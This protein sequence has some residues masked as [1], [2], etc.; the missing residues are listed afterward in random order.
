MAASGP[1]GLV[2]GRLYQKCG[3]WLSADAFPRHRHTAPPPPQ[4]LPAAP[5]SPWQLSSVVPVEE[6]ES[7]PPLPSLPLLSPHPFLLA[8][9]PP[10]SLL[11]SRSLRPSIRPPI[12]PSS[13][14]RPL[15]SK[16]GLPAELRVGGGSLRLSAWGAWGT[17]ADLGGCW[18]SPGSAP[19]AC[20]SQ[21]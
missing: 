2:W 21:L 9:L 19:V 12:C 6:R 14:G 18:T 20:G 15:V 5:P 17:S 7:I 8:S 4:A 11:G 10:S 3:D 16:H 13:P 1:E